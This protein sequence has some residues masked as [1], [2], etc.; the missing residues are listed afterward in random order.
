MNKEDLLSFVWAAKPPKQTTKKHLYLSSR[1]IP[2][3]KP[4]PGR[5]QNPTRGSSV[6]YDL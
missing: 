2:F 1:L 3:L 4:S 5:A 6:R